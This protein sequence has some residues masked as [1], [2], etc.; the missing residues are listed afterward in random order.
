MTRP[1]SEGL[2]RL[3]RAAMAG[4]EAAGQPATPSDVADILHLLAIGAGAAPAPAGPGPAVVIDPTTALAR[5]A[6]GAT[7]FAVGAVR[8]THRALD[9]GVSTGPAWRRAG[10][11]DARTGTGHPRRSIDT[12]LPDGLSLVRA[13]RPLRIRRPDGT[14]FEIDEPA[15]ARRV[16]EENCWE[17]VLRRRRVR[18]PDL[19]LV[20]DTASSMRLWVRSA[21]QVRQLMERLGAFREIRTLALRPGDGATGPVSLCPLG[22][23]RVRPVPSATLADPTGRRLVVVVTDGMHPAWSDGR[24]ADVLEAWSRSMPVV[25]VS[26]VPP[27]CWTALRTRWSDVRLPHPMAPNCRWS[28]R[29]DDGGTAD[30]VVRVPVVEFTAR[31]LGWL[32]EMLAGTHRWTPTRLVV[33]PPAE[34]YGAAPAAVEAAVADPYEAVA[35][36]RSRHSSVTFELLTRLAAASLTSPHL[37]RTLLEVTARQVPGASTVNVAEVVTSPLVEPDGAGYRI[38]GEV[39]DELASRVPPVVR[40]RTAWLVRRHRDHPDAYARLLPAPDTIALRLSHVFD[41]PADRVAAAAHLSIEGTEPAAIRATLRRLRPAWTVAVTLDGMALRN[42]DQV[43]DAAGHI[44]GLVHIAYAQHLRHRPETIAALARLMRA[45]LGPLV[46]LTGRGMKSLLTRWPDLGAL[47]PAANRLTADE[48]PSGLY[49]L[50]RGVLA[51]RLS[52]PPAVEDALWDRVTTMTPIRPPRL[53]IA[54]SMAAEIEAAWRLRTRA[55][56]REPLTPQD[57]PDRFDEVR[58]R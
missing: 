47:V 22:D 36:F 12:D 42:A 17:P 43:G 19:A 18:W 48:D 30:G 49:R 34:G 58:Y 5:Q 1:P 37:P 50:T 26:L 41:L 55:D 13:L 25:V 23:G 35:T 57:L 38:R 24:Y 40:T 31:R 39:V 20:V 6:S 56:G 3:C 21:G 46:L 51:D 16:A 54:V 9:P 15:T 32:A 11:T 4:L 14:D 8:T 2:H 10:R 7:G 52:V 45:P 29:V 28:T 27:R 53:A 33:R 44:D